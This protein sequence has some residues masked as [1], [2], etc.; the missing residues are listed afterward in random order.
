[1]D[2]PNIATVLDAGVAAGR[3]F[4]VMELIPGAP[5]TEHCDR[6]RLAPRQRL[7]LFLS[8]CAAVQHAHQ[9]GVIHRDLKPSNI[10][11]G[12]YDGTAVPKVVDFGIAKPTG[13]GLFEQSVATEVGTLVGTL[14]YMSPEQAELNNQDVDTRSDV[15]SLGVVLYELLTGTVPFSREQLR[16]APFAEVLRTLKEVEPPR[17]ST[18]LASAR[19]EL[20]WIV[21]KCLEKDRER[22]YDTPSALAR[23]VERYLADE[24]VQAGPPSAG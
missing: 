15:Y 13:P 10:L 22:R 11:V 16:S 3:P 6:A 21:M 20:D 12:L 2:H 5:I 18:R 1:M 4:F 7:E 24:P 9:K 23:D 8:V 17:P 14:E 19:G